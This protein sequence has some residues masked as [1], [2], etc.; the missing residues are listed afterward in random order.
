MKLI[1]SPDAFPQR[2]RNSLNVRKVSER[3]KNGKRNR[4]NSAISKRHKMW[5]YQVV[6]PK[7]SRYDGD[8]K[9]PYVIVCV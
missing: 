7:I 2:F 8:A 3:L 1:L 4:G 9:F 6:E 5:G